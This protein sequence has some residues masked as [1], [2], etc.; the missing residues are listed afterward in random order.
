VDNDLVC[1]VNKIL[2]PDEDEEYQGNDLPAETS[3][4][5]G[6]LLGSNNEE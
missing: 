3:V 5:Q 6:S 2:N 1:S 4:E